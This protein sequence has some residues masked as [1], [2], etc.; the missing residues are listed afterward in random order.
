MKRENNPN[1]SLINLIL[2]E[3]SIKVLFRYNKH[4]VEYKQIIVS[5]LYCNIKAKNLVLALL[6][7][8]LLPNL[9]NL[10]WHTKV[11]PP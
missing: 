11:C 2:S 10:V 8:F 5:V 9:K 7:L 6:P 1:P 4:E 3:L